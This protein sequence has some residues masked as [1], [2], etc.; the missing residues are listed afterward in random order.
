MQEV[1]VMLKIFLSS[2]GHLASGMKSSLDI[3]AGESSKLTVFDAYVDEQ[4]VK[5]KLDE[6]YETV[7]DEDTVVLLSDLYG[8]SVNSTMYTYLTKKNT[9]LVAGINLAFLLEIVMQEEVTK[10]SLANLV[11]QSR[12]M[13]CLVE[14][15][16]EEADE[17]E[18]F[19]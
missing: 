2:H 18:D 19:L 1:K 3:L 15:N 9:Y 17:D 16:T 13:M 10:E 5:Q 6:F 14:L 11:A 4:S 12:E 7:T 8:G